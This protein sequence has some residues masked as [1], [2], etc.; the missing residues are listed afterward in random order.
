[1]S[2]IPRVK[3]TE[4]QTVQNPILKYAVELGWEYIEPEKALDLRDGETGILFLEIFK[5]KL[6]EFNPW[7]DEEEVE[8]VIRELLE[9]TRFNIE[10]NQK[11]LNYCRGEVPAFSRKDNREL[12]VRLFDFENPQNNVFQ[13]TDELS[14]T[15]GK[16]WNRFDLVFYINGL[17]VVVVETKNPEKEEGINEALE[18]IR[19]YHRESLEFMTYPLLFV[20]SNLHNFIYGPT[21]NVEERY[22]YHW[23]GG[24]NLEEITKSFFAFRRIL[25]FLGDYIIFWEEGGEVKKIVLATH[26]IRAVEKVTSRVLKGEK[27]HG[28]IWH[29]QGSGKTLSM[30]VAAHKLRKSALLENPTILIVVDRTELEEQMGRNLKNYGFPAVEIAESREKLK[31]L[32]VSDFRGLIVTLIHKFERIPEKLNERKNIIVFVDEA[33]RTQEGDLAVYMRSALPN[34]FYFG[35]TGTPIDKTNI[36]KGT[37]LTFGKD[38]APRGYLDK[39]SIAD[40]LIDGTTVPINYTLAPN[41]F[42]VP[43]DIL[44]KEFYE[45]VQ[46]EA[47]TSVEELDKKILDKALKLRNLLKSPDR[48]QKVAEF[49]AEHFRNNVESLGF[50]AFLVGV[51]REACALLKEELDKHLPSEY[52]RVVFTPGHNDQELLKKY[53]LHENEEKEIKKNFLKVGEL[54]KILIVTS[55]LLTGFDAPVLYAMYLDK[56]MNDHSLLQAIARVNRPLAE[57]E[58]NNPKTAGLIVDFIGI[59]EK[60]EKALRFDSA[61]IQGVIVNLEEKKKEFAELIKQGKIYLDLVGK[62]IDDKAVNRIVDCFSE[63]KKRREFLEF[64]RK[65]ERLY[66]I[67][68]PDTFLRPYL[69]DYFLLSGILKVLKTHFVP[70]IPDGLLRKTIKLIQGK[71]EVSGLEKTLPVYSIDESAINLIRQDQ[72][73]ERVKIIKAHWSIKI[74]IDTEGPKEPF[75]YLFREKIEKIIE[76]FETKQ[77]GTKEALKK[78]EGLIQEINSARQEKKKLGL[79]EKDFAFYYAM[80]DYVADNKKREETSRKISELF[81][82]YSNWMVNPE[83]GRILRKKLIASLLPFISE[84]GEDRIDK[85]KSIVMRQILPLE[86]EIEKTENVLVR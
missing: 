43:K 70:R 45:L 23:R 16:A 62:K 21:W 5:S 52:S 13:V 19:R 40:S 18:Q 67:I 44:E 72:S 29:T 61:D 39:Y 3:F 35:F 12:N 22:L 56:P 63:K 17:P 71:T 77:I 20:A 36:G 83:S 59:F 75:L 49:V 58:L 11:V 51:D 4:R 31:K 46:K 86:R 27:R 25:S 10:G 73:P 9:R 48:I 50:K 26:Q 42:L 2:D 1:M 66:E 64:Y 7:L 55:K 41:E 82:Q 6:R 57:K 34:A 76:E 68:A 24:K 28:L 14:F 65:L 33:H 80:G 74:L 30:I 47:I 60:L 8:A 38:D 79:A 53:H 32:L 69:E 54:P 81:S 15:N 37:F 78:F 85:I 84:Q